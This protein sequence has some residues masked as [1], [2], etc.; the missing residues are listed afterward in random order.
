V[1]IFES[2]LFQDRWF[3]ILV[4]AFLG[5]ALL[6]LLGLNFHLLL[7]ARQYRRLMRGVRGANLEDLLQEALKSCQAAEERLVKIE[8]ACC[9]LEKLTASALQKLGFIRFN[10]F[11]EAG[12]ELSFALALLS[13]PGDGVVLCCLVGRDE[14]R[15]YAKPVVGGA[16]PYPLSREERE[17]I[18]RA[19][20]A[21]PGSAP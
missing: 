14:C 18:R 5:T 6:V 12:N 16:S 8:A 11:S 20:N 15:L 13:Q 4:F 21:A 17:A 9:R 10:A 19:L 1:P 7:V 2:W 3:T